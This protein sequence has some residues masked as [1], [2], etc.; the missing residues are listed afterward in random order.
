VN[1]RDYPRYENPY[2]Q[3]PFAGDRVR[4]EA[5]GQWLDLDFQALTRQASGFMGR[6]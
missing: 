2:C 1:L 3:A 5:N 4:F 6:E